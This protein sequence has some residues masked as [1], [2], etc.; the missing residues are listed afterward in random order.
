MHRLSQILDSHDNL[1][2]SSDPRVQEEYK[3]LKMQ[4]QKD[5]LMFEVASET[6]EG[7]LT[8]L[9]NMLDR[10]SEFLEYRGLG[11]AGIVLRYIGRILKRWRSSPMSPTVVFQWVYR[12]RW[13]ATRWSSPGRVLD[14]EQV[15]IEMGRVG[16]LRV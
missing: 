3:R 9:A 7:F 13:T 1:G 5:K 16:P 2:R 4:L 8:E 6:A 15:F 14:E 10:L 11:V 12:R